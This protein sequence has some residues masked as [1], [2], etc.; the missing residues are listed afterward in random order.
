MIALARPIELEDGAFAKVRVPMDAA[1]AA[2]WSGD[3]GGRALALTFL[4]AARQASRAVKP[5]ELAAAIEARS[6]R[7]AVALFSLEDVR[8]DVVEPAT[9]EALWR[10]Y[11]LGITNAS[12]L[13]SIQKARV[14]LFAVR[15]E[16]A[17]MRLIAQSNGV[18]LRYLE[19][20]TDK[21]LELIIRWAVDNRAN[22]RRTADLILRGNLIGLDERRVAAVVRFLNGQINAGVR[23]DRAHKRTEAYA[24]RLLRQRAEALARTEV[25]RLLH[26]GAIDGWLDLQRRGRIPRTAMLVWHVR[27]EAC[28]VCEP[29]DQVAVLLG[30]LFPGG[31][32]HP[33][34][35]PNCQCVLAL[36][37][38]P[39]ARRRWAV[40]GT[41]RR[42][43]RR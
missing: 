2:A 13:G 22:A 15:D 8:R 40:P 42:R 12:R 29:L 16:R 11:G 18:T 39:E 38:R 10:A 19:Q 20:N 3:G 9:R 25:Q 30:A 34:I 23:L 24:R 14:P 26:E 7:D 36:L 35:H 31:Y 6:V 5:A 17:I 1:A 41:R 43:F 32:R 4:R 27:P 28:P 33:P 21:A 37:V